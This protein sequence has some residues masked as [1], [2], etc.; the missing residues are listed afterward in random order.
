MVIGV[1]GVGGGGTLEEGSGI[2]A[3]AAGGYGLV[4]DY[5]REGQT[6]GDELEGGFSFGVFGGVE[7]GEAEIEV[8]F[9]GLAVVGRDL[10]QRGGGFIVVAVEVILACRGRAVRRSSWGR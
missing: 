1:A 8:G 6:A 4:V 7:A 10:G 9:E 2:V 3:L 5:L